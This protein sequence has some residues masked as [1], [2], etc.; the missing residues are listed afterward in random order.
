MSLRPEPRQPGS[1]ALGLTG[2]LSS[3][4]REYG[5]QKSEGWKWQGVGEAVSG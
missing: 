1:M 3:R 2:M 5:A 4:Q